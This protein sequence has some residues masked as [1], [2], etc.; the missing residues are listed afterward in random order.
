MFLGELDVVFL[1]RLQFALT[2]MFHYIFP[3][4]TIGMGVVLVYLEARYLQTKDSLYHEAAHFWTKIFALNFAIGVASG[5]VME[6]EFGTNWAVYSRFVGDVFGSALAAEGIFAFFLES[7]FLAVLV[8]GWNKVGPR[9]HFFSTCMVALGSIFS[10]VWIVVANSWQQTPAGHHIV[11]IMRDGEP[12]VIGGQTMMRAEVVDF[13]AVVFNPSTIN[14]LTHTLIGCFIMGAFFV[15]SISAWYILKNRHTEFARR[16]FRGALL[17]GTIFS[18]AA[19]L[20]GH[21]NARM[22]ADEQPAKLAAFEGHFKSGPADLSLFGIPDAENETIHAN[23]AIPGGL[24]FLVHE[25]FSAP[26]DGLDKFAPA[27][28]P[29]LGLSF[30][31]YHWMVALGMFFI[32]VT[33][34]ASYLNWRGTLFEKRWLMWVFVF[35]VIAAVAAN[36]LGWIAAEVGR[37]PWMVHPPVPRDADGQLITNAQGVVEYDESQALR[38]TESVSEAIVGE[39]VLASIIMFTLIYGMLFAVWLFVLDHKIKHGP[40]ED[41]DD[42]SS[43]GR[44][45]FDAAASLSSHDRSMTGM[46]QE[47]G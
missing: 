26:V 38:T 31:S 29:P 15:M 10:S 14:R 13:W 6:F 34:L 7:G 23:I 18:L 3:P 22:V 1:S 44:G 37:Q 16:S 21:F 43:G 11:P 12:W 47:G 27:D 5:I 9:L 32:G 36:Q 45:M 19:P 42:E 17:F 28:R 20:S 35:A 25:D 41:G 2:I 4:L 46:P 8:F 24:S 30:I 33:V 40:P 39:Q